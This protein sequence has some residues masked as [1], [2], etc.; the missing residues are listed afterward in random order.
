MVS[1]SI[2]F[3][4]PLKQQRRLAGSD[5]SVHGADVRQLG[6]LYWFTRHYH[7]SKLL[8]HNVKVACAP[9]SENGAP[10]PAL[11]AT[12]KD[13]GPHLSID[14]LKW[15]PPVMLACKRPNMTRVIGPQE[16]RGEN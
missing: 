1:L 5:H 16:M 7:S 3:A 11:Q 2:I 12:D 4:T 13:L 15:L 9:N 10:T 6:P 8:S 14:V